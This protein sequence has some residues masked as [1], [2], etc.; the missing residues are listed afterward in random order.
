[1]SGVRQGGHTFTVNSARYP[2]SP[3][4]PPKCRELYGRWLILSTKQ[5]SHVKLK[6]PNDCEPEAHA[7]QA[8]ASLCRAVRRQ[9]ALAA[10]C[11]EIAEHCVHPCRRSRL[12]CHVTPHRPG[13]SGTRKHLV[14]DAES[15]STGQRWHTFFPCLFPRS[16][17]LPFA[18]CHPM[19]PEPRRPQDLRRR[20]QSCHCCDD[21]E[22]FPDTSSGQM[23]FL[24]QTS[25]CCRPS[26]ELRPSNSATST[27]L[28]SRSIEGGG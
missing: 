3:C 27:C 14:R 19:G 1:M 8:F 18:S 28:P 24:W 23:P 17:V 6:R 16:D 2:P 5:P 10:G 25:R 22:H 13:S 9:R 20:R 12:E 26:T 11:G 15:G 4:I 7:R 21:C